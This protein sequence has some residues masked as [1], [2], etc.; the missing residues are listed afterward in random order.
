MGLSAVTHFSF[1]NAFE[2]ATII[3][4]HMSMDVVAVDPS[5]LDT[6]CDYVTSCTIVVAFAML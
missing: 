2:S 4:L 3:A 1:G 6:V 5:S